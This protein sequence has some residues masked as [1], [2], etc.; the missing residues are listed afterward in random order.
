[1][2]ARG[3]EV[4]RLGGGGAELSHWHAYTERP[5]ICYSA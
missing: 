3:V 1:M 5:Q 4:K 2:N